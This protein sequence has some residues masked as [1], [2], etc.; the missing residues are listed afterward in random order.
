MISQL[1]N[2]SEINKAAAEL[3]QDKSYY[4]SVVHCAYYSCI[5][6]MKHI[7]LFTLNKTEAEIANEVRNSGEG[8][9]EI[10]INNINGHLR[11]NNKDWKTFNSSINQLK[12]LRVNAD[13]ENIQIDSTKG[14]NSIL[15]SNTVLKH[16]KANIKL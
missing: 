4:P 10:M 14:S 13:Y 5:Q 12:R 7:L 3:L 15:L 11:S 2:K 6:L 16:L 1:S 8:S 9:H